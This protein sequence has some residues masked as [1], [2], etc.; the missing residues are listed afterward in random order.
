M[1]FKRLLGNKKG[2]A[3][4]VGSVMFIIILLFFFT[5]VYLWH[6]AA[7]KQMNDLQFQKINSPISI[8]Y[9][10][11]TKTLNI[12]DNGGQD[13]VISGLWVVPDAGAVHQYFDLLSRNIVIR[14]GAVATTIHLGSDV[15]YD[16][17]G[18]GT[19]KVITKTGNIA[20][21]PF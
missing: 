3:E 7:T 2:T 19:L 16:P 9:D 1:M 18:H 10:S 12:T 14:A 11:A 20:S 15:P 17:S 6:D 13:A 8:N 21:C 5:N 4:V